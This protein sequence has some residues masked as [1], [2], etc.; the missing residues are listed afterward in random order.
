MNKPLRI[1]L[2]VCAVVL[3][4]A[5]VI[6]NRRGTA[7]ADDLAAKK[8]LTVESGGKELVYDY[9]ESSDSYRTFPAKMT[10]KNGDAFD[11]EYSGIELVAIL[12]GLGI[13]ITYGSS[14]R[15]V[16]ADNY[17]VE[18]TG[19]EVLEPGN[20]YIVT[21]EGGEPLPDGDGP[22]MMVI[23]HDEFSTRWA[24]QIVKIITE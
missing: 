21:R 4:T 24:R 12:G 11:R 20:I 6:A 10:K 18:L 23:C 22:F 5:L 14:V 8:Q 7:A 1:L 3:I 9:D 15:A 16:C 19:T 2:G 13:D 17:E